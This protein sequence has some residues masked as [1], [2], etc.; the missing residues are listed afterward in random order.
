MRKNEKIEALKAAGIEV[1]SFAAFDVPEGAT[2]IIATPDGKQIPYAEF[3]ALKKV[4]DTGWIKE[5]PDFRRW[6]TAQTF[7][8]LHSGESYA[9]YFRRDYYY[10]FKMVENEYKQVLEIPVNDPRYQMRKTF[11]NGNVVKALCEDYMKHLRAFVDNLPTQSCKGKPY[12]KIPKF[13]DCFI[14]DI[15][16]RL[17]SPLESALAD[18][19]DAINGYR[20]ENS[21]AVYRAFIEFRKNMPEIYFEEKTGWLKPPVKPCDVWVAAF[22]GAGAYY[23][24]MNLIKSHGLRVYTHASCY[25][26]GERLDLIE[27]V[28]AV[29]DKV[30]EIVRN[31]RYN[32]RTC[33][34][35][36]D[37]YK[38]TGMLKELIEDNNFNFAARMA[39]IYS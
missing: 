33:V 36:L 10:Q 9:E 34:R 20:C 25:G 8:I 17:Y 29:H 6:V 31:S 30:K 15:E 16:G 26:K 12:K 23:T 5:D 11:F 39:E 2:V 4:K 14:K 32:Y 22:Q 27:S 18:I 35:T 37:W 19:D 24:M 28:N 1:G 3:V 21:R 13:G 38:L 7:K